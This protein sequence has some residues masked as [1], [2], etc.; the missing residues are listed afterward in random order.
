MVSFS[1]PSLGIYISADMIR[2]VMFRI[3]PMS[4]PRLKTPDSLCLVYYRL[5]S[6]AS[7][8]Y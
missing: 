8:I 1:D 3:V 5:D 7:L 6:L 2:T 4:V